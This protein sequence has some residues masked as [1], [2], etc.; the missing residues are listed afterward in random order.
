MSGI[1]EG[2]WISRTVKNVSDHHSLV[3]VYNSY[4]RDVYQTDCLGLILAF[5]CSY[6]TLA[7]YLT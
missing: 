4:T 7:S 1:K 5:Q 6:V 2:Q 3:N